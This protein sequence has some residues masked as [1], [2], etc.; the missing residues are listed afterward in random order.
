M[1]AGA[2]GAA[3]PWELEKAGRQILL[4]SLQQEHSPKTWILA[5]ETS[6]LLISRNVG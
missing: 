1:E 3:S 5:Y 6:G 2:K 4:Q